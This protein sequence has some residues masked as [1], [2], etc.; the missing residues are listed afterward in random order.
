MN[1]IESRRRLNLKQTAKGKLTWDITVEL[2]NKSNQEAVGELKDLK[3]KV[4]RAFGEANE[5]S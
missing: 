1:E 2:F 4:E 3:E 5:Q